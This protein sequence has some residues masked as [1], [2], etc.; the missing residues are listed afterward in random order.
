MENLTR[1]KVIA[2][3]TT[4]AIVTIAVVMVTKLIGAF[5]VAAFFAG[6]GV[7]LVIGLVVLAGVLTKSSERK[8]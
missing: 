5:V 7:T 2:A 6:V 4:I 3:A 1:R 8:K